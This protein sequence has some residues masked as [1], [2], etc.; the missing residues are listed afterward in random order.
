M[1]AGSSSRPR[2]TAC[3]PAY[4]SARTLEKLA[5][6]LAMQ[7]VDKIIVA[8]DASTDGTAAVARALSKRYPLILIDR[9]KNGGGSQAV[10]DCYLK[11]LKFAGKNDVIVRMDS[12]LEHLPEWLPTLV[13][14]II[15]NKADAALVEIR[16]N[17][18]LD[19]LSFEYNRKYA[20][21]QDELIGIGLRV[22]QSP[23]MQA[24]RAETL[25]KIMP[26]II[27]YRRRYEKRFGEKDRVGIDLAA[28]TALKI[29]GKTPV[30]I[31]FP[32]APTQP[33][34]VVHLVEQERQ[35][36]RH[37]EIMNEILEAHKNG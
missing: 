15:Q 35:I 12:D 33:K 32:Q 24:F 34:P 5:S 8:N 1:K 37:L 2:V 3:I 19:P 13:S 36:K 30:I 23:G 16:L 18:K 6:G 10:F 4:N 7:K 22:Q 20:A 9:K 27:E 31:H 26:L 17:A 28:L 21:K 14:P 25:E 29:I 11:A